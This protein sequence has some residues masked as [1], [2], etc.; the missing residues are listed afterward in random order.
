[1]NFAVDLKLSKHFNQLHTHNALIFIIT[2]RFLVALVAERLRVSKE[3]SGS[4]KEDC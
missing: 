1:M 2:A 3:S 4:T